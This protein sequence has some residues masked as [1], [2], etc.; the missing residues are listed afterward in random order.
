MPEDSRVAAVLEERPDLE[1]ALAEILAV[2]EE[3]DTWTFDD[4]PVESGPF[5]ELVSREIVVKTDGEYRLA[6]PQAVRAALRDDADGEATGDAESGTTGTATD[7]TTASAPTISRPSLPSIDARGAAM[8]AASLAVVALVRSL[9]FGSVFRGEHV[10]LSAND[11]YFYRYW[12]EQAVTAGQ[13]LIEQAG[14]QSI[15]EPLLVVVLAGVADL[16]GGIDAAGA[17]LAVYPV[18]AAVI[19]AGLLYWLTLRITADRRVALAAVVMLAITPG[20]ALRTALGFAD[21]H[22]FD[23]VWLVLTMTALVALAGIERREQLRS[24][25]TWVAAA[26]LGVGVGFQTLAWNNGPLL[27]VPVG[28]VLAARVVLDLRAGRSSLVTTG[29]ALAGIVLGALIAVAG[30]LTLGWHSLTVALTPAVLLAGGIAL[31]AVAE[32]A[33]LAGRPA[34]DVAVVEA[35]VGVAG[36]AGIWLALPDLWERLLRGLGLIGRTDDIAE[37]EALFSGDTLGFLL[38]FGFVLVLAVPLL[39]WAT[40]ELIDGSVQWVVPVAYGW[41]FFLLAAFQVRFT[42]QLAYL[43]AIFAGLAFVWLAAAVEVARPPAVI[44]EETDLA[45]WTPGRPDAST[46]AAVV[47]LFLLVGGLGVLQSAI[48]VEQVTIDDASYETAAWLDD[49]ADER[50]WA[51]AQE[52]YVLSQWGRNRMYNYFVNGQSRSYAYARSTYAD[53]I[54]EGDPAA[55][56]AMLGNR[57]RFVVLE[58]RE[59]GD[60][61]MQARLHNHLGSHNGGVAG[62]GQFRAVYASADGDRTAFVRVPGANVTG[63]VAPNATVTLSTPVDIEGAS[64]TYERQVTAGP[65]GGFAVRVAQPGTYEVTGGD[66]QWTVSVNET[67]VM[68]G[69][70]VEASPGNATAG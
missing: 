46:V 11:P 48:K 62:T 41:Y 26:G 64:F 21:H 56:S 1:S 34:R 44:D 66:R 38:L 61:T 18:A 59:A 31:V 23:Y 15:G 13:P 6:D 37:V 4:V 54:A 63:S 42:G 16:F 43:T 20:H 49:Y 65:S 17:V 5:G 68:D 30:H 33:R 69:R 45:A 10:V 57:V 40:R 28:L 12:V 7:G 47:V 8:L 9:V 3:A 22:A 52:S 51:D 67:A 2:D 39:A 32:L 60:R 24:W 35:L 53:F 27:F 19:T 50:G 36:V 25:R 70:P 58:S 55:A 14:G 29:P